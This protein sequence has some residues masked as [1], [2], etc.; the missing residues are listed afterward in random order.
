M[1]YP[2]G[3]GNPVLLCTTLCMTDWDASGAHMF[4]AT[5][6]DPNTY[7][8]PTENGR[9]LPQLPATGVLLAQEFKALSKVKMVHALV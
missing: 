7:V 3:P 8:L 9:G 6:K 2:M 4:F 1:A 5:T